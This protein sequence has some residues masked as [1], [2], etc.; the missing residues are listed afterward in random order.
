M[1]RALTGILLLLLHLTLVRVA[2]GQSQDIPSQFQDTVP[3]KSGYSGLLV[4]GGNNTTSADLKSDDEVKATWLNLDLSDELFGGYYR[5]KGLTKR[6]LNIALGTD[7]MFLT[8]VASFSESDRNATS[9]IFRFFGVWEAFNT[10]RGWVGELQA[11]V[12]NRHRIGKGGLPRTLGYEAGAALSTASFKDFNWGLTNFF[13][14]QVF[15]KQRM[16]LV[17]GIMDAGDWLDLFPSLNPYKFY[18]NEAFFNSPTTALPNQGFGVAAEADLVSRLYVAGGIH[19]A[20]GEAQNFLVDNLN[21]FFGTQEYFTWVELGWRM[22]DRYSSGET[23]HVTYWQ[24]DA[25]TEEGLEASSGWNFSASKTFNGSYTPFIRA[26]IS[27][28]NAAA[29]HHLIQAGLTTKILSHDYLGIGVHWGGPSDRTRRDQSGVE[30]FYAFQLTD[31]LNITPDVQLTFN[32]SFNDQKD[33]V[34]VYSVVRMR[35]AM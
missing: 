32:P 12:E 16:G 8:Q 3:S 5:L 15:Q 35:Y 24:Q 2:I 28:G 18:L 22:S 30:L 17:I 14:K 26:G 29:M 4:V 19:D 20:N 27:D 6:K 33:V 25:R 23:I 10:K 21:S 13:W 9:G 11:K 1:K 31:N 7:Y 34:A